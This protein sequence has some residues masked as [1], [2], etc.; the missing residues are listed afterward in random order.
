MD[1][2]EPLRL[3]VEQTAR[4][5]DGNSESSVANICP[6]GRLVYVVFSLEKL[7]SLYY[8]S[9]LLFSYLLKFVTQV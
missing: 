8:L 1:R 9:C 4:I 6:P 2:V 5:R 7:I 3:E